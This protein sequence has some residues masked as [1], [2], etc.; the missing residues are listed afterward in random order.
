MGWQK[1]DSA[2]R[3]G[4]FVLL[5]SPDADPERCV[6]VGQWFDH[7]SYPDGG[8]WWSDR[9]SDSFPIDA[10]PS[11]WQPLPDPPRSA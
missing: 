6:F 8:A 4:T 9:E 11:H 1:I 2:P 5:F 10:D 3:D 7:E